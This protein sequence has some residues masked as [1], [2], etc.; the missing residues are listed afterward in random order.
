[1]HFRRPRQRL[2]GFSDLNLEATQ[3]HF[4][5]IVLVASESLRPARFVEGRLCN[6]LVSAGH[7]AAEP[8]GRWTSPPPSLGNTAYD[9][10]VGTGPAADWLAVCFVLFLPSQGLALK[11]L[12]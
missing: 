2:Q 11:T 6:L 1:M 12:R 10:H 4:P 8:T 5:C 3:H 7:R 9:I